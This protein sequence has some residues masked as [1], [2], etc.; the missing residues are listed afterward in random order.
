MESTLENYLREA[1]EHG[2]IDFQLRTSL[3]GDGRVTFYIHP[4]GIDG[5]TADFEVAGNLLAHNRDIT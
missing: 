2:V 5:D 1:I 3:A 4:D